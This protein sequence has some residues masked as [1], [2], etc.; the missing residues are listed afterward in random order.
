MCHKVVVKLTSLMSAI[1]WG[2][3]MEPGTISRDLPNVL[4]QEFSIPFS[5]DPAA[6]QH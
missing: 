1:A 3:R 6:V 5:I 4:W 2:G